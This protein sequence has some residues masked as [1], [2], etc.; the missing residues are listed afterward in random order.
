MVIQ[1]SAR[2]KKIKSLLSEAVAMQI[3]SGM[4]AAWGD[5]SDW[6]GVSVV[7]AGTESLI[8]S[9]KTDQNTVFDLASLTK[10]LATTALYMKWVESGL[11][12][13][14]SLYPARE[15]TFRQLLAHSSGLPA[16]KPFYEEMISHFGSDRALIQ[17]PIQERKNY[18]Y[19]LVSNVPVERAPGEKIVYSDLGFI[20]LG[21]HAE[22]IT[23]I[24]LDELLKREVWNGIN[25]CE[26]EYRPL[27]SRRNVLAG[28][29][30]TE[31]C[32]W[33]G[34][35]QGEVHDDNAWSMGG[36]AGHAGV[37]G[38]VNDVIAWVRAL[39][40]GKIAGFATLRKFS[41]SQS[42]SF[43]ARRALGFDVP[44]V[45]GTGST[46]FVFPSSSIGHLGFVGTSLWIDLDQGRFAILLTNR[47]H[48]SREDIRIRDLRRAFHQ[49][50][51]VP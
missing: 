40:E 41:E 42:D 7:F 28:I 25:G 17:T 47:V 5:F 49:A 2:S 23:G 35:L 9:N 33:R 45:D 48:P 39:V 11:I 6:S 26:L 20:L 36:V 19:D 44:A 32:P 24:S 51:S 27:S 38:S 18:F 34:L 1:D 43:G 8:S 31:N 50:L 12:D 16:W 29:A 30:A 22:K 10:I 13:L 4:V 37:F 21:K 14:D 3:G 46:G 15:F